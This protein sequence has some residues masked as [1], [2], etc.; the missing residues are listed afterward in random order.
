[1]S[2]G[3]QWQNY[4]MGSM[5]KE[6]SFKL[7]DTYFDA[8]VSSLS[9]LFSPLSRTASDSFPRETSSTPQII[10]VLITS[11]VTSSDY[12]ISQ[13]ETSEA[14]IGEWAEK[15]GIR[16]QLVIATKVLSHFFYFYLRTLSP[17]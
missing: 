10:S 13:D 6:S 1:M 9:P 4:G 15:R 11:L 16:D 5:D 8:G 14:F 7:L 3:D 17:G 12:V 2:I